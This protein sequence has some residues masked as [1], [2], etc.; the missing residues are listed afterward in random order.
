MA[1]LFNR[2]S[3]QSVK[4]AGLLKHGLDKMMTEIEGQVTD[5]LSALAS[6]SEVAPLTFYADYQGTIDPTDQLPLEIA[7]KRFSGDTDVTTNAVWSIA[8]TT[9]DITAS[10]GAATGI[11]EITAVG[12]SGTITV[13]STLNGIV[14]TRLVQITKSVA[15]PPTT[16]GGGTGGGTTSSDTS[17]S[18][19]NSASHAA[20]SDELPV[21]VSSSGTVTLSATLLVR[22]ARSAPLGTYQVWGKWQWWNG[23]AWTDLAAEVA[24]SPSAIVQQPETIIE[25]VEG[26]LTVNDSKSGLGAGTSQKFRLMARNDSGTRIM[27]FV[28]TASAVP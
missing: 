12:T 7:I 23:A 1:K 16:S 4:S 13:S 21:T 20:I 27:T 25:L 26:N 6:I 18:S 15:S 3:L 28:G 2:F 24:S 11:L 14:K 17:F 10:I 8:S 22:T 9:G 19:I 5:I